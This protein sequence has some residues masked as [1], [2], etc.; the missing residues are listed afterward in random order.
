MKVLAA[1]M[2]FQSIIPAPSTTFQKVHP[3][4]MKGSRGAH[5]NSAPPNLLQPPVLNPHLMTPYI[6]TLMKNLI[7]PPLKSFQSFQSHLDSK[8]T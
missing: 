2:I 8:L 3:G 6:L 1:F 4:V 7:T 5:R